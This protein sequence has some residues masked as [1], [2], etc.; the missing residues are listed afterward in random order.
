MVYTFLNSVLSLVLQL[1]IPS[2]IRKRKDTWI[3]PRSKQGHL[4]DFVT[5][6]MCDIGDACNVRVLHS[7]ER[8]RPQ[9]GT[10]KISS[11]GFEKRSL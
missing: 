3:H 6:R 8:D 4:I 1:V 2:F 7:G 10:E 5:T 11:Y 9:I